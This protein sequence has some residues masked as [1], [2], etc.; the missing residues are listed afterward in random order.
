MGQGHKYVEEGTVLTQLGL[1]HCNEACAKFRTPSYK[2]NSL[3]EALV[4]L[5]QCEN[6]PNSLLEEPKLEPLPKNDKIISREG[7][8]TKR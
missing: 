8:C 2:T 6:Q 7:G 5:V 4:L 1:F 3:T